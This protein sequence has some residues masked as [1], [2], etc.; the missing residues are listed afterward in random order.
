M[1]SPLL[2]LIVGGGSAGWMTAAALSKAFGARLSIRVLEDSEAVE[3]SGA[4][5]P[6][7]A[8]L[9][10]LNGFISGLGLHEDA[11]MAATNA[12]FRLGTSFRDWTRRDQGYVHPLSEIGGVLDGVPFHHHWLRLRAAGQVAPIE[13]FA[14]AAV[15]AR[16]GRFAR[17]SNDPRS[18]AST[19]SYGLHLEV[20]PYV[21][22]LKTVATAGRVDVTAGRLAGVE[23]EPGGDDISAVVLADGRSLAAD[24]FIDATGAEGSLITLMGATWVDYSRWLP[25]DR[26]SASIAPAFTGLP[27]SDAKA[28]RSGWLWRVPLLERSGAAKVWASA[29]GGGTEGTVRPFASGRPSE[30]W[31]G[32]C[33][34]IGLS[35]GVLEPLEASGLH[36]VQSGVSKL[37]GLFPTAS[38]TRASAAEYNR[39]MAAEMDRLR[40]L[41]ILHHHANRRTGEPLWDALRE[42]PP[43][44]EL[45]HKI[46]M[47]ASRGR[48]S[49][50]DEETFEDPS[51]VS[52]FLGQGVTPRRYHPLADRPPLEQLRSR[53]DA[54]RV[55]IARAA[56]AMP[57]H[58]EALSAT[59]RPQTKA[60]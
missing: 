46:R 25:C 41:T 36:R 59:L 50:Y 7:D 8:T 33:V 24:L 15:A 23:R 44:D 27:L 30:V 1:T 12:T 55:V 28:V 45:A 60:P 43:P 42:T 20:A 16:K 22:L 34:A 37:I 49:L 10:S 13:D 2:V 26:I 51:W 57:T 47:F 39:L 54:M 40:D 11:V 9:P 58:A 38:G 19:M 53:L 48:V 32:N 29:F 21:Q 17:P 14:L 35:A 6:F 3:D 31:I 5:A 18:V 52:V 56:D 4:L